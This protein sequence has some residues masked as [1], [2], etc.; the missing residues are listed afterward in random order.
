MNKLAYHSVVHALEVDPGISGQVR[1]AMSVEYALDGHLPY[2]RL[3]QAGR[4]YD[5]AGVGTL[6]LQ[7][8]LRDWLASDLCPSAQ[9]IRLLDSET[10]L[11]AFF[12]EYD[13]ALGN[14]EVTT[15]MPDVRIGSPANVKRLQRIV[16][17]HATMPAA[18]HAAGM[19]KAE[20]LL[21]QVQL[22]AK[23]KIPRKV[24]QLT[25]LGRCMGVEKSVGFEAAQYF[26]EH[27]D[28]NV[29]D[30]AK[31]LGNHPRTV[32]R[33]LKREG[34]NAHSIRRVCMLNKAVEKFLHDK[35][36]GVISEECSYSDLA[37]MSRSFKEA[38]GMTP[39]TLRRIIKL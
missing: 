20:I 11:L 25:E 3:I 30:L 35:S 6:E 7:E 13:R 18:C 21:E 34:L 19:A 38:C 37:H 39:S 22:R 33:Q 16:P 17:A 10:A 8:R 26:E 23:N 5:Q 1:F 32:G 2:D 28:K 36:L 24:T 29:P 27:T 12:N 15:L 9:L 14:A 4:R 31:A